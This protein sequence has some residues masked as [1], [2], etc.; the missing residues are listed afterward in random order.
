MATQDSSALIEQLLAGSSSADPQAGIEALLAEH[1]DPRVRLLAQLWSRRAAEEAEM[2]TAPP[3]PPAEPL[4]GVRTELRL[5]RRIHALLLELERLQQINDD[6]AAAL[7]AC[8]LCWGEEPECTECGGQGEPGSV[9][10]DRALFFQLVV[11]ALRH[12]KTTD[13]SRARPVANPSSPE[14]QNP[15]RRMA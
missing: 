13:R 12:F 14:S 5:R 15:E 4:A 11:P 9:R 10:P 3:E 8:P 7:G 2:E 6:L 1:A